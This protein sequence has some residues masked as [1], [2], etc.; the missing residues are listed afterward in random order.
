M[1]L[2]VP[3]TLWAGILLLFSQSAPNIPSVPKELRPPDGQTLLFELHGKGDQIYVCQKAA[4]VY[5]WKF[6]AP[7]AALFN[8]SGE[9]AGRHSAGPA[10][11]A[12][13]GSRITGKVAANVPSP[14]PSSIPLLLLTVATHE[15]AG[16]MSRVESIQRLETR[17]GIAPTDS[18][19]A[20]NENDERRVPYE[21]N[22]FFYGSNNR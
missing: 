10:W 14:D 21:A 5:I 8:M 3:P 16:I 17:G 11:E 15:G 22:Y 20:E 4:S 9:R 19:S 2:L 13:D 18:C 7:A 12:T 6:K 1:P